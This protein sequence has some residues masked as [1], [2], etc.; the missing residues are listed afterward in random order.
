MAEGGDEPKIKD[1]LAGA[2][3]ERIADAE[4]QRALTLWLAAAAQASAKPPPSPQP[5][6]EAVKAVI[7]RRAKACAAVDPALVQA[8]E[9]RYEVAPQALI[10]FEVL[11]ELRVRDDMPMFDYAMI[12]QLST[13]AEPREVEIPDEL[14]DELRETSPQAL[15]R[16]LHRAETEFPLGFEIVDVASQQRLDIVAAVDE[17]MA[18]NWALPPL[19]ASPFEQERQLLQRDRDQI[20]RGPWIEI[21]MPNRTVSE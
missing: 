10:K 19:G 13:I 8:I 2:Q 20:Y 11:L 1:L 15:L 3:L 5:L 4:A 9:F 12:D 14:K 21:R 6:D 18:T 7:E 16:D 17:A